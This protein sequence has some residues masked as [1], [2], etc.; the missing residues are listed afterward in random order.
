MLAFSRTALHRL[1]LGAALGPL[2]ALAA[3]DSG[4]SDEALTIGD[5]VGAPY[6]GTVRVVQTRPGRPAVDTTFDASAVVT[7]PSEGRVRLTLT[8]EANGSTPLV[9]EGTHGAG[10][11]RLSVGEP[12]NAIALTVDEEGD[13]AGGGLLDFFGLLLDVDADG[14]ATGTVLDAEFG[15]EVTRG[16]AETPVGTRLDV[17]FDLRR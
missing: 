10:G 16:N 5:Y 15:A 2:L 12:P 11:L 14:R 4:G 6:R 7:T 1:A 3:C 9:F 17:A 8:T 13:I